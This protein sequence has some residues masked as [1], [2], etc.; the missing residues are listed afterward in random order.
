MANIR[1]IL[2]SGGSGMRLWPLSN[3]VRSKQ[4]LRLL[5]SPTG[6]SESMCQR[7]MR[8]LL[9]SGIST[10][11]TVATGK[12]QVDSILKQMGEHINIVAEPERRDTFPA[13]AL[14]CSYLISKKNATPDDVVIVMPIDPY[15]EDSYFETVKKMADATAHNVANIVLMGI[16]P[17]EPSSKFGY[18]VP[19]QNQCQDAPIAV[20][21]FTEKPKKDVAKELIKQGAMW[22]GGVF[23]FKI[24]YIKEVIS[25]YTAQ[26]SF[27]EIKNNYNAFPKKSF[28]FEILEKEPSVAVIPYNGTWKDLGT[29]NTLTEEMSLQSIGNVVVDESKNTNIVNELNIPI[30]CLGIDNA[31]IAASFDGIFIGSKDKSVELKKYVNSLESR[32]MYEERRWGEYKVLEYTQYPDGK[33]SL[34]KMLKFNDGAFISYQRHKLRDEIW[35]FVAGDGILIHNDNRIK[36]KSGDIARIKAGDLHAIKSVKN[37]QIIEVQIGTEL[38]ETDIERLPFE[39]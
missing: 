26:S 13:I 27:D 14:A 7:M 34:T 11:I 32:P 17:N 10:D 8:Q 24:K 37:L 18:I 4:F 2:L 12:S 21:H 35:T 15:T 31:I 22:N 19:K 9:K 36:V 16:V 25:R 5:K 1:I 28:D 20:S 38:T 6:E 39:W 30:V 29:W 33:K 3:G 23:A